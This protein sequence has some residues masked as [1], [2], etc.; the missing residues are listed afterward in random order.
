[1]NWKN[2]WRHKIAKLVL[3]NPMRSFGELVLRPVTIA[4]RNAGAEIAFSAAHNKK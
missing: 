4:E 3:R 1:M 2:F